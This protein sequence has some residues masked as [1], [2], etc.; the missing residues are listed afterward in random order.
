MGILPMRWEFGS[1]FLIVNRKGVRALP[2]KN[3]W[4]F[5]AAIP[6]TPDVPLSFDQKK[7]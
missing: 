6:T 3:Q 2:G 1:P 7:P 5:V 4:P